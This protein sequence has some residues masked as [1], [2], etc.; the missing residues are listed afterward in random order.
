MMAL[1]IARLMMMG[2]AVL[3]F[4]L[5]IIMVPYTRTSTGTGT[6]AAAHR[7]SASSSSAP[8]ALRYDTL[9]YGTPGCRLSAPDIW[10]AA[11]SPPA[12]P[13]SLLQ[14]QQISCPPAQRR[15][16][17]LMGARATRGR[18]DADSR[19]HIWFGGFRAHQI[20]RPSSKS[21][22]SVRSDKICP[23]NNFKA[24]VIIAIFSTN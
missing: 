23:R 17:H 1:A 16:R 5:H 13:H 22:R 9:R 3:G 14:A 2:F 11:A 20:S 6:L 7:G 24:I 4:W 15:T 18:G 8:A 12:R 21:I 19:L 10:L